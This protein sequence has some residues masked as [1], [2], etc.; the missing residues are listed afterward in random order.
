MAMSALLINPFYQYIVFAH[1]M[2]HMKAQKRNDPLTGMI[3]WR[4]E[5]RV[6]TGLYYVLKAMVFPVVMYGLKLSQ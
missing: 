2:L 3:F 6:G 5:R 4:I 1:H